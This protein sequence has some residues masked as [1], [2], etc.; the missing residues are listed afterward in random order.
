VHVLAI[1]RDQDL[2]D[3]SESLQNAA[4]NGTA[5]TLVLANAI[6]VILESSGIVFNGTIYFTPG[7]GTTGVT[8]RIRAGYGTGG[9]IVFE[10]QDIAVVPGKVTALPISGICGAGAC[11]SEAGGQFSVTLQQIGATGNGALILGTNISWF[12][13]RRS[14]ADPAAMSYFG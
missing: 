4:L 7:P 5:E 10:V 2:Y 14:V 6:V 8:V 9:A 12:N 13:T 11:M 3:N 1:P